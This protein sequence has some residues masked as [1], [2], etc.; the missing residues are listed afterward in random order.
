MKQ[1][2]WSLVKLLLSLTIFFN[3]ER[4]DFSDNPVI[5]TID[6]HTFVYGVAVIAILS[7]L[8]LPALSRSSF[9]VLAALWFVVFLGFK[10]LLLSQRPLW[11]GVYTYL[12]LTE[13]AFLILLV[14]QA[15]EL[16]GALHEV[17]N[18]AEYVALADAG[19]HLPQL[20]D[21]GPKIRREMTRS[22]YYHRALSVI[23]VKPDSW[24]LEM[25]VPRLMEE[26]QKAVAQ[27]CVAVKLADLLGE[28]LRVVDTV[29]EDREHEAFVILC[30]EVDAK[31]TALLA[32]HLRQAVA[33]QLGL[34]VQCSMASFPEE[35][36]TFESLVAEAYRKLKPGDAAA[37]T[38]LSIQPDLLQATGD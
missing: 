9:P 2:Y 35:A 23:V 33:D 15:R 12:S 21:A 14:Y 19:I 36:I 34:L 16:A 20:E 5:N 3:I 29:L 24:S 27:R 10:L 28:Q 22:R 38:P 13:L 18:M 4:F 17:G 11:G 8:M 32:E 1:V 26:I 25:T 37:S 6:L 31:G 30:P 7:I